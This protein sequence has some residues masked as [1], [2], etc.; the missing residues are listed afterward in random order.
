MCYRLVAIAGFVPA[1]QR[2]FAGFG[3]LHGAAHVHGAIMCAWLVLFITQSGLAASRTLALHR[4]LGIAGAVLAGI[5][6]LSMLVV[7]VR[8]RASALPA[9]DSF[10]WDVFL[11][12]LMLVVV[13]PIFMTWGLLVRRVPMLHKRLMGFAVAVP[14]QA[15]IDRIRWPPDIDLPVHWGSDFYVYVLLPLVAFDLFN[16]FLG[17]VAVNSLWGSPA[18]HEQIHGVFSRFA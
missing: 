16:T 18:W 12:E 13:V 17:H 10:L 1:Y 2:Y 8:V 4:K 6:W 9:V 11:I 3:E 7:S 5:A 14:L 15:S